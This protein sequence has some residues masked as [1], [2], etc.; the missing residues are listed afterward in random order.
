MVRR[1]TK[2]SLVRLVAQVYRVNRE[3][4]V[5]RVSM[6][7]TAHLEQGV[8]LDHVAVLAIQV[9]LECLA[10]QDQV[11]PWETEAYADDRDVMAVM[12]NPDPQDLQD[13]LAI[14]DNHQSLGTLAW[15]P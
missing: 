1:E 12:D 7:T 3:R 9:P 6:E 4:K 5:Q 2:A 14:L 10:K 15:A 11:D 8:L 13:L